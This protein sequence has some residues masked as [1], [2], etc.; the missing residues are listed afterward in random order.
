VGKNSARWSASRSSSEPWAQAGTPHGPLAGPLCLPLCWI[1]AVLVPFSLAHGFRPDYLL[2]CYAAAALMGAWAIEEIRRRRA[3]GGLAVRCL[4]H[5]FAAV[6][7][8]IGVGLIVIP[9]AYLLNDRL[10]S[11]LAGAIEV[12]EFMAAETPWIAAGL[13][14]LGA[15]IV[16]LA[17]VASLRWRIGLLAGLT[18]AGML[19]VMFLNTHFISRHA[20]VPDSETMI[21]FSRQVEPIIGRDDFAVFRAGKLCVEL[22]LGRFGRPIRQQNEL[23]ERLNRLDVPWLIT[24][25]RGLVEAGAARPDPH[26]CVSERPIVSQRWG[27][28]YL[29]EIHRPV[30]LTG[31]PICVGHISGRPDED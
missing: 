27:R 29:I 21:A 5:V 13:V 4:R 31:R 26:V 22:Y 23:A 3:G 28:I 17:I 9:P 18:V 6:P 25:D 20:R 15:A 30:R 11:L 8:V 2:P 7:I 14:P 12:P 10:P 24:C 19:G 1:L 16:A